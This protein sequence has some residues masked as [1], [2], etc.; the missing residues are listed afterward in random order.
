ME[1]SN[2]VKF[3]RE[4]HY[5]NEKLMEKEREK[6]PFL[7]LFE[8]LGKSMGFNCSADTKDDDMIYDIEY[9]N[10]PDGSGNEAMLLIS[11]PNLGRMNRACRI[12]VSWNFL[13]IYLCH[14]HKEK[15][16][17]ELKKIWDAK[18]EKR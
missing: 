17:K 8:K 3:M 13:G 2:W 14:L 5:H 15:I 7:K 1:E 12:E 16:E 18:E 9:V 6:Y 11:G 4:C 10:D